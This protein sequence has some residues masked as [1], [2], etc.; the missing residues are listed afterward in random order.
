IL[1][2]LW[3]FAGLVSGFKTHVVLPFVFLAVTAWLVRRLRLAHFLLL[4][5]AL[6]L[7]YSVVEPLRQMRTQGGYE[8]PL[9]SLDVLLSGGQFAA[10]DLSDSLD[11][12][13]KRID[14]SA[15]AVAVLELDRF[16]II[17]RYRAR[18]DQTYVLIPMLA[19]VPVAVWPEKPLADLGRDLSIAVSRNERNSIT[20]SGVVASYLWFGFLGVV[21]NGVIGAYFLVLAGRLLDK[22]LQRPLAYIPVVFL[23]LVFSM[24]TSIM[25][26]HYISILRVLVVVALFYHFA[27]AFGLTS[28]IDRGDL[29]PSLKRSSGE[30]AFKA[31]HRKGR[32]RFAGKVGP[33]CAP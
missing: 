5:G 28:R 23:V 19:F 24:P 4:A 18:L 1:L 26:Y 29:M 6:L 20:P 3:A 25:A 33:S 30:A 17:D 22:Y 27:G 9:D 15:T 12:F 31:V 7:A 14:Y 8:N 2:C 21:L 16:G 11:S 13:T 10:A 32:K